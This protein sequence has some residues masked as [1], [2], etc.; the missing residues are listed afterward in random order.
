M[1][2]LPFGGAGEIGASA[3]LV[4]M[5][6]GCRL[7]IDAGIRVGSQTEGEWL[8][9]W[10]MLGPPP[11]AV[12]VTHAHMD[13]TG[14]ISAALPFLGQAPWYMTEGTR[15]LIG[16]T[17]GGG[18]NED[19]GRPGNTPHE[20]QALLARAVTIPYYTPFRPSPTHPDTWVQFVPN[21]HIM[22]SSMLVIEDEFERLGWTGDYSVVPTPTAGALSLQVLAALRR[23]R[24]FDAVV[25][26]G[27][28]GLSLHPS[29]G[30]ER[31]KLVKVLSR[32]TRGGGKV[33]IPAFAIGRAQDLVVTL[34][35]AKLQG[36]LDQV[37]VYLD[38]MVLPVTEV[39]TEMAHEQYPERGK[40]LGLLD[41]SLD[42]R[43]ATTEDRQRLLRDDDKDPAIV[44]AS[45]GMLM[46]GRSV[47]YARAWAG[48][49][50]NG[51]IISGYQDEESPGRHLLGLKRG[52]KLRIGD[53]EPIPVRCYFGRY[54][55]SAH[56]D[57][58]RI[59]QV[60]S[61]LAPRAVRFVHGETSA[62][63]ALVSAVPRSDVLVNGVPFDLEPLS[64]NRDATAPLDRRAPAPFSAQTVRTWWETL[65]KDAKVGLRTVDEV[66]DLLGFG[67]ATLGVQRAVV[68]AVCRHPE[69]FVLDERGGRTRVRAGS[70]ERGLAGLLEQQASYSLGVSSG[71]LVVWADP[72]QEASLAIIT[73]DRGAEWGAVVAGGRRSSLSKTSIK[74]IL[75]PVVQGA[76]RR[77][78]ATRWLSWL[79]GLLAEARSA[80]PLPIASFWHF[81]R[82]EGE[83]GADWS[84]LLPAV[85]N[86]VD[87]LSNVKRVQLALAL[88]QHRLFFRLISG[89]RFCANDP[90]R[91][92]SEW[93]NYPAAKRVLTGE[94]VHLKG[95]AAVKP[96]GWV[97]TDHF[98]GVDEQGEMRRVSLRR[99]LDKAGGD[100]LVPVVIPPWRQKAEATRG[101][102]HN[103][104][105]GHKER[106]KAPSKEAGEIVLN[107]VGAGKSKKRRRR[108]GR[109]G[110]AQRLDSPTV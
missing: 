82:E 16:V 79:S 98:L 24:P 54:H 107:A 21:G 101:V 51:I 39:Y 14:G 78:P 87:L 11:D 81:L 92:A 23:E 73:E 19:E 100:P 40:P 43:R 103:K 49:K 46:G 2:I 9:A 17:Q 57:G 47:E 65:R 67:D 72:G 89:G 15:A 60:I 42:I 76:V 53:K 91:V 37:P 38:G 106:R 26:E 8:P 20:V 29:P 68:S 86:N 12:L 45:S 64:S 93:R 41:T 97:G 94:V 90:T 96:N 70:P 109:A 18:S 95:G 34:R 56:A 63:S 59:Q 66:V 61:T 1:R 36:H 105:V 80:S 84:M 32:L 30:A 74:A 108:R 4:E 99:V 25:S 33:L 77:T 27:T 75:D 104:G 58:A 55:A 3:A 44:I 62:L 71:D 48:R 88:S 31:E 52:Q 85:E 5:H 6:G 69:F 22:G 102:K 35:T 10:S 83:S 50:R 7:V 13:H 28:Y 110:K